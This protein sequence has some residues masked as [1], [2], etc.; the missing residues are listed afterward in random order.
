VRNRFAER[1]ATDADGDPSVH[2]RPA[3]TAPERGGV[4]SVSRQ[5]A[6][7]WRRRCV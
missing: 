2:R 1:T 7:R 6:N 5:I 4:P 3:P